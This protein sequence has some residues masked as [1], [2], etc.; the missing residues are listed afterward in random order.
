MEMIQVY[1]CTQCEK[2]FVQRK[3]ICPNCKNNELLQKNISGEGKVFSHTTIHVSSKEFSHLTPYSVALIELSEGLRV[4]GRVT[5]Q[6]VI[7][8]KVKCISYFDNTFVFE[9]FV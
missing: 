8:D 7:D 1:E 9:K 6:V 4:T 2:K 5:D 3:W